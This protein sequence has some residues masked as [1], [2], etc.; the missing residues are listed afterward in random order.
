[1]PIVRQSVV[2]PLSGS[3]SRVE[4][5]LDG[6]EATYAKLPGYIMG[7][8]YTTIGHPG[9]LGRIALWN[10]HEEADHAAQNDHI[11]AL[12]ADLNRLIHGEH[13]ERMMEVQG[14]PQNF[15]GA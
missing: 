8:R 10:S 5:I 11:I 4:E 13:I 7:F 3:T 2:H 9:E 12:R 6:L 14:N 15:P 1:M